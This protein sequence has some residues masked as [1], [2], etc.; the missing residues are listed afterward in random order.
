MS[1]PID[2][3]P[4]GLVDCTSATAD[5]RY[6]YACTERFRLEITIL[7]LIFIVAAVFA[8]GLFYAVAQVAVKLRRTKLLQRAP[9]TAT[10][11]AARAALQEERWGLRWESFNHGGAAIASAQAAAA[12]PKEKLEELRKAADKKE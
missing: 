1:V 6:V 5:L 8:V 10:E 3:L 12:V 11:V 2:Y 7:H 4:S 9:V